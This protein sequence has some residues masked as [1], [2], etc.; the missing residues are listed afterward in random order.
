MAV[1]SNKAINRIY[2]HSALH[3]FGENAGGVFVN[4]YFIKAGVPLPLV[5]CIFAA[6]VMCRFLMRRSVLPLTKTLGL[7]NTLMLGGCIEA[8]SYLLLPYVDGISYMLGLY[9]LIG[10]IG[11]V[12]YWTCLHAYVSSQ[13]DQTARGRQVSTQAAVAA[14]VGVI[15]PVTGGFLMLL[16]GAQITFA[17]VTIVQLLASLSLLKAPSYV[18]KDEAPLEPKTANFARLLY[19]AEGLQSACVN[20]IWQ[21]ALFVALAQR[22]DSYGGALALAGLVG[23]VAS[24]VMGQLIDLGHGKRL[25][26]IAYAVATCALV[27]KAMSLDVSWAAVF[28]TALGAL[29]TP[30]TAPV[31]LTPLYNMAK[32]SACP[33]RFNIVTEGGWDLGY[34]TG[35]IIAAIALASGATVQLP[36]LAGLGAI[37]LSILLLRRYYTAT[38]Q[39]EKRLTA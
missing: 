1:F 7:R 35:N 9:I 24:L 18:I 22:F 17:L 31:L 30:L 10:S 34:A 23:A 25:M 13:G 29:V 15:A 12:I 28:A 2:L 4:A 19:F 38:Q 21:V 5:F 3:G 16:G 14:V 39:I 20:M 8:V 32:S 27:A 6:F 33:V 37:T 36:I 26:M 11:S